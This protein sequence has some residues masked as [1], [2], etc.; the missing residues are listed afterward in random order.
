MASV[1][2]QLQTCPIVIRLSPVADDA[3]RQTE[4]LAED[5]SDLAEQ[6]K[7][8][9]DGDRQDRHTRPGSEMDGAAAR[10]NLA[11]L[12][13]FDPGPL[14]EQIGRASCRERV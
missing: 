12:V 10:Q 14:R 3:D 5:D 2:H 6:S 4:G 13:V 1:L 11:D 8:T 9:I 7:G